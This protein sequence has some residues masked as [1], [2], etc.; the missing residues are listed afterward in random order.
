M[1]I[2]FKHPPTCFDFTSPAGLLEN[3]LHCVDQR[4]VTAFK[5]LSVPSIERSG[6][7]NSTWFSQDRNDNG[8]LLI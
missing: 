8:E 6:K 5:I 2:L 4:H 3:C 7:T 1:N